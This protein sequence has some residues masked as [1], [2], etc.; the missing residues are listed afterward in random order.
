MAQEVSVL[1]FVTGEHLRIFKI[2]VTN[3]DPLVSAPDQSTYTVCDYIDNYQPAGGPALRVC[4]PP[5]SGRYVGIQLLT[6][7]RALT[8]CEVEV[9]GKFA[10]SIGNSSTY[11]MS[12]GS[13]W[14]VC[15]FIMG[16]RQLTICEVEV[17]GKFCYFIMGTR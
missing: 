1:L 3:T 4:D 6:T 12:S 14:Q 9:Y 16:A 8:V 11:Y 15:Y 2:F 10:T 17:Y 7:T 13:I 5:I